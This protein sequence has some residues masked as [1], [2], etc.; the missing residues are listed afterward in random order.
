MII[1]LVAIVR[2]MEKR[3]TK[4][5]GQISEIMQG[6]YGTSAWT[7]TEKS[8]LA[9]KAREACEMYRLAAVEMFM[10]WG[11]QFEP[12]EMCRTT[13][14][15]DMKNEAEALAKRATRK[16]NGDVHTECAAGITEF[17]QTLM[18]QCASLD[19]VDAKLQAILKGGKT[20]HTKAEDEWIV[21]RERTGSGDW[22]WGTKHRGAT[23]TSS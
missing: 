13:I 4:A 21:P 12:W 11:S 14:L 18:D 17:S 2:N 16:V 5:Q 22:K 15:A 1:N 10:K 7:C 19:D 6:L 3:F 20:S 23:R 8:A 9:P